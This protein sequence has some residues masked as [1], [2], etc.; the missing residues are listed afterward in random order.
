MITVGALADAPGLSYA[1]ANHYVTQLVDEGVL[2]EAT[3]RAL[4]RIY[5]ADVV[6][7]AIDDP[8]ENAA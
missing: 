4:N 2:R 3:G 6:P 8:M 5:R 1:T 7:S